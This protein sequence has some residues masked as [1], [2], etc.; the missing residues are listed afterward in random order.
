[1]NSGTTLI[2]GGWVIPMTDRVIYDQGSVWVK[3]GAIGGVFQKGETLPEAETV[4]DATGCV[5][6]PGLVNTHCHSPMSL[7]RGLAD[8]MPLASWLNDHIFPA[9]AAH[10]NP[11]TVRAGALLSCV[12]MLLSGTTTV[13]DG[14]FYEGAVAEAVR[15]VGMR[16][17]LAHGVIDFPAPGVPDPAENVARA[18]EFVEAWKDRWSL[19]TPSIFCHTP[20]TCSE[21]TLTKAKE[22]CRRLGVLFQIHIAET[23][24]EV[25][26]LKEE[27]G[28]SP[29]Q[30]L[31]DLHVLDEATLLVHNVWMNH[32]DMALIAKRGATASHNP[33][34]NTK[35]ASGLCPAAALMEKGIHVGLGTDGAA[36][37]NRLDLFGEMQLTA[38]IHKAYSLDPV[39]M[40]AW[41]VLEMATLLGAKAIGSGRYIGSLLPGKRADIILVDMNK[42]HL[43]PVHNP[44][45][46]LVYAATGSDVRDVFVEGRQVV[47]DRQLLTVDVQAVMNE[48]HRIAKAIK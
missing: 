48:V 38:K 14:Y 36:S 16:G 2:R 10:I 40:D 5:V 46:H 43:T 7:F 27:R 41:T 30:L 25:L 3:D 4:V 34:S 13:C 17:V 24:D 21:E 18:I 42:P 33:G 39:A 44:V 9:E 22:A 15:E 11:E 23:E 28:I 45:S 37:N 31:D 29:Y 35:L 32:D 47:K 6:M 8:D 26:R 19:I 1:M 20:Y 12:E